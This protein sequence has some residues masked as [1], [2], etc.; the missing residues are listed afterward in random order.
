M[1]TIYFQIIDLLKQSYNIDLSGF[2]V[3]FFNK[4][5]QKRLSETKC[6]SLNDYYSLLQHNNVETD[7]LI[8][9]IHINYSEFFRNSLTFSVLEKIILPEL[10]NKNGTQEIRIWSAACAAGQEAYSL[11]MLLEEFNGTQNKKLNYRIFATDQSEL[12]VNEAKKGCFSSDAVNNIM[13]KRLNKWFS[14]KGEK[15]RVL[16]ELKANINFSVFDLLNKDLCCP[17]ESVFGDFDIIVCA[18]LLFYYK[19][20]YRKS[21]LKKLQSCLSKD[22]YIITGEAERDILIKNN[23]KEISTNSSIFKIK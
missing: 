18:N 12:Q 4:V 23:Y 17:P 16:P 14:K 3:D 7:F 13:T 10:I 2:D 15:Y 11:A 21:I 20:D 6:Q 22:G 5:I 1:N 9:N 8:Q 19:N